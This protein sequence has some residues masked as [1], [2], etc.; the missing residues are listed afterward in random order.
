MYGLKSA[1]STPYTHGQFFCYNT[2]DFRVHSKY[3]VL[4]RRPLMYSE[5]IP[6]YN[7]QVR[8]DCWSSPTT[9]SQD[10]KFKYQNGTEPLSTTSYLGSPP[11]FVYLGEL[12]S[13]QARKSLVKLRAC[14]FVP[15]P[16]QGASLGRNMASQ[17]NG[18]ELTLM[19]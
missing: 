7:P 15:R 19:G 2:S 13:I 4:C 9:R 1:Q 10:G 12:R 16:A 11:Y 14:Q 3:F 18:N 17:D 8:L 6:C 5:P